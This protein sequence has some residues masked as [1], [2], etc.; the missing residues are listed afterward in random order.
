MKTRRLDALARAPGALEPPV[1]HHVH[2]MKHVATILTA[3]VEHAFHPEDVLAPTLQQVREP[4]VH[5]LPVD[6]PAIGDADGGDLPVM[7]M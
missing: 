2:T 5:L 4:V 7:V 1:E 6:G 3:D